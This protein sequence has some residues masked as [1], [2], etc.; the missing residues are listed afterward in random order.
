MSRKPDQ[1]DAWQGMGVG[2]AVT[3]TMVSGIAVWGG[4]GYLV[5]RLAGTSHPFT[6][7]GAVLGSLGATYIVYLRYGKEHR[8]D[9]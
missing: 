9:S 6:A 1:G 2:W 4:I 7:I 8:G 3:G 5:D